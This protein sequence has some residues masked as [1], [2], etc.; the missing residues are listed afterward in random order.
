MKAYRNG[1]KRIL[2]VVESNNIFQTI[3]REILT[4][5]WMTAKYTQKRKSSRST[6]GSPFWFGAGADAIGCCI[7]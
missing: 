4:I 6:A 3:H 2:L 5:K 1:A 7:A